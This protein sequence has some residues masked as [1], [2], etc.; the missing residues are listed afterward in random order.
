MLTV[1]KK[2]LEPLQVCDKVNK[3]KN[4]VVCVE[5]NARL[6]AQCRVCENAVATAMA[7]LA[8]TSD[9]CW[10]VVIA[11]LTLHLTLQFFLHTLCVL[12]QAV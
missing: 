1:N 10:N 8:L 9:D 12:Q 11:Q 4:K 7:K 3:N 2:V 6:A 5:A